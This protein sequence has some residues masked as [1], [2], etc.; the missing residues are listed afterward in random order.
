MA[1]MPFDA[2][3]PASIPPPPTQAIP[4]AQRIQGKGFPFGGVNHFSLQSV[5]PASHGREYKTGLASRIQTT[6]TGLPF[7]AQPSP[8]PEH[9]QFHTPPQ[10]RPG[11]A[12]VMPA[13]TAKTEPPDSMEVS[14]SKSSSVSP[15]RREVMSNEDKLSDSQKIAEAKANRKKRKNDREKKRRLEINEKLERLARTLGLSDSKA[16][17]EKYAVL[18]EAVSVI[19]SLRER[20][21]ELRND[22]AQLR[23]ELLNLTRCLQSAF[24]RDQTPQIPP[25]QQFSPQTRQQQNRNQH[26]RKQRDRQPQS[27]SSS[28]VPY[29]RTQQ[30]SSQ[31]PSFDS[32]SPPRNSPPPTPSITNSFLPPLEAPSPPR[33]QTTS[34]LPN[35]LSSLSPF[36][37]P[38]GNSQQTIPDATPDQ[39][40]NGL[41]DTGDQDPL[42]N[43]FHLEEPNQVMDLP[44]ADELFF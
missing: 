22:K 19:N 44:A 12:G 15:G 29:A 13:R 10:C 11:T 8:D 28:R 42:I 1:A 14:S 32:P 40:T 36:S 18:A 21:L 2:K 3:N 31:N 17:S 41:L 34:H 30:L 27:S 9:A 4:R 43:L 16:K 5:A 37:Y 26:Q 23:D 24:P 20:N 25:L 33:S 6:C 35:D 7:T 39:G 38:P